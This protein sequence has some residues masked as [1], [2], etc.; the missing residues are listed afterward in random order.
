MTAL[1]RIPTI[2]P[3]DVAALILNT[4]PIANTRYTQS[5][6]ALAAEN[7]EYFLRLNLP[8]GLDPE[9]AAR[10]VVEQRQRAP[11]PDY[12]QNDWSDRATDPGR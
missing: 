9:D 6:L 11:G 2:N 1:V 7:W 12:R 10:V 8:P 4:T 5:M 3:N